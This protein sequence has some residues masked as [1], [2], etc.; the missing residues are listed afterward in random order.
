MSTPR[1]KTSYLILVLWK[2][3]TCFAFAKRN[4]NER[5]TGCLQ[6]LLLYILFPI[7]SIWFMSFI[8]H[9]W[10]SRRKAE[11]SF[12]MERRH[13]VNGINDHWWDTGPQRKRRLISHF[14]AHNEMWV[15]I[16]IMKEASVKQLML[17]T[18]LMSAGR[19][20]TFSAWPAQYFPEKYWFVQ[21]L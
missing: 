17:G 12:F 4:E 9:Y 6:F 11:I 18:V 10:F 20:G 7:T 2:Y 16:N 13:R 15:K 21:S 14:L 8:L 5:M 1:A 3:F 19:Q